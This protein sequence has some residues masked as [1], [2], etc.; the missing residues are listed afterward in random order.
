[1]F[2]FEAQGYFS[3]IV[4]NEKDK[5]VRYSP[6]YSPNLILNQGLDAIAT[7]SWADA[8]TVCAV[9]TG[10]SAPAVTQTTL[11]AESK[12]TNVYL[13]LQSANTCSLSG[14]EFTLQ[15]TFVF[16][17]ESGTVTYTEGAFGYS[18][19][20]P[21]NLFS[22]IKLPNILVSGGE[23]LIIQYQ[24][25][26]S[27]DLVKSKAF[28]NPV[29][30]LFNPSS[31][32]FQYQRL[33]LRGINGAGVSYNFDDAE[34]C[35]EPSVV[36]K[37]FLSTNS[38]APAVFGSTVDR[39]GTT[40][41]KDV[42]L[43]TYVSGSFTRGKVFSALRKE[44]INNT[45]RSAGLGAGSGSSFSKTGLVYVFNA[46]YPKTIGQLDLVY[47]FSWKQRFLNKEATLFYWQDEEHMMP[48]RNQ[49]LS[50]YELGD[51]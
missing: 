4:L 16:P 9:G 19:I 47:Q 39:S 22:R 37:G 45:W 34:G 14:N 11:D 48:K 46:N 13:D 30:D 20:G 1:M 10:T 26:V 6:S 5:I 35:N 29:K 3:W 17:K 7:R 21:G 24:L 33:G 42:S 36:C 51:D 15:R 40:F 50:Y 49:L 41:E 2:N 18:I 12:R 23:R 25:V 38:S 44:A 8:F 31:G 43:S 32:V 27:V 28:T